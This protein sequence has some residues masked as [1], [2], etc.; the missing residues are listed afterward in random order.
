MLRGFDACVTYFRLLSLI[1]TLFLWTCLFHSEVLRIPV[2][3]H[4]Q[5]YVAVSR[6]TSRGDL[7]ILIENT[8]GSCGSQT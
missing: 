1:G 8:D 4:C 2:F 6:S 3:T 7:R 5:L